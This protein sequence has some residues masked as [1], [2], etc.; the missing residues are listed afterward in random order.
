MNDKP[1]DEV[2]EKDVGE[3][4]SAMT[5]GRGGKPVEKDSVVSDLHRVAQ[6]TE[7]L[8]GGSVPPRGVTKED[9]AKLQ[10]EEARMSGTGENQRGGFVAQAQSIANKKQT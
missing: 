5:K 1:L 7:E 8:R 6:T 3:L 2:T 9:T 10:S 4:Q